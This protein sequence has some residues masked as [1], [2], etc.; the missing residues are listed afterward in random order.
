MTV[1]APPPVIPSASE[2]PGGV[3]GAQPEAKKPEPQPKPAP[4]PAP[5][6][7]PTSQPAPPPAPVTAPVADPY[8]EAMSYLASGNA[9]LAREKF[10]EAIQADPHNAKAHFRLAEIALFA[11]NMPHA[12]E[13]AR[14]ALRDGGRLDDRE[15]MLAQLVQAMA[16]RQRF[17]AEQIAGDIRSRWPDDPDL[18]RIERSI[19]PAEQQRRRG[20]RF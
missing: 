7:A 15:H 16:S 12:E 17:E 3:G 5:Q 2:G 11:R 20:R 18:T 9:L 8:A 6:P 1:T 13:Q 14:L 19:A 10:H 4:A